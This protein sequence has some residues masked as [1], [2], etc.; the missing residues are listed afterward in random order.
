MKTYIFY[1]EH[2][3]IRAQC[4]RIERKTISDS[5]QYDQPYENIRL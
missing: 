5:T 2:F 3:L 4:N 1:F